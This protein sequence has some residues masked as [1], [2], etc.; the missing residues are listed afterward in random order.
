MN[1]GLI[2]VSVCK[3]PYRESENLEGRQLLVAAFF[4]F[5][6]SLC[7]LIGYSHSVSYTHLT[8]PTKA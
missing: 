2:P 6:R 5:L 3:T 1:Y 7:Y 8:L 4:L